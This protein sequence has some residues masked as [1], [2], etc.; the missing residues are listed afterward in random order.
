MAI[1]AEAAFKAVFQQYLET[2]CTPEAIEE[3]LEAILNGLLVRFRDEGRGRF[4]REIELMRT[5]IRARLTNQRRDFEQMRRDFFMINEFPD[6][7]RRFD[8]KFEDVVHR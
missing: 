7:D 4:K 5:Q 8:L 6:N 2:K 1:S 3:R